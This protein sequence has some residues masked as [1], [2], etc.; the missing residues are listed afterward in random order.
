M[1]GLPAMLVFEDAVVAAIAQREKADFIVTRNGR[2]F[3]NS[4][5]PAVS[6]ADFLALL[7][8]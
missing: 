5:V 6:P 4:P 7:E 2:H 1:K 8:R 3:R